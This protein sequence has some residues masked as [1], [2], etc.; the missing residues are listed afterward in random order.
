[1]NK[2]MNVHINFKTSIFIMFL[3]IACHTHAV[4]KDPYSGSRI[5]WDTD[6][7]LTL[8][9]SG[10]YARIIQLQDGRS[11]VRRRN[12]GMLQFQLRKNLDL[13]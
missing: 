7:E 4:S 10:N 8:F 2:K 9:P 13:P 1:M 12:I 11:R 6:S 5:F 3:L